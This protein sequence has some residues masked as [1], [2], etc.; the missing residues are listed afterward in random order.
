MAQKVKRNKFGDKVNRKIRRVLALTKPGRRWGI[1][2]Y[3]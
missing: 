2:L 1:K 3:K